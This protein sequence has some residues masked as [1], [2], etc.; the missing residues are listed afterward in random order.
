MIPITMRKWL[1][2]LKRLIRGLYEEAEVLVY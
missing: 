1:G 2:D